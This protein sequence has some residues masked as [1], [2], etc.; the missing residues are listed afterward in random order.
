MNKINKQKLVSIIMLVTFFLI[1][2]ILL[3]ANQE[4]LSMRIKNTFKSRKQITD[5]L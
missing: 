2:L 3:L 1:I 5:L 4:E